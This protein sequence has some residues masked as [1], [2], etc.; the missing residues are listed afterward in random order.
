MKIGLLIIQVILVDFT[1]H[2]IMLSFQN[3]VIMVKRG[4]SNS[5]KR[6]SPTKAPSKSGGSKSRSAMS[7]SSKKSASST[8]TGGKGGARTAVSR[9]SRKSSALSG[10]TSVVENKRVTIMSEE[11]QAMGLR[12]LDMS[13]QGMTVLQNSLFQSMYIRISPAGN[14]NNTPVGTVSLH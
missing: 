2:V 5:P 13:S 9:E 3:T 7:K 10:R 11:M 12:M 8:D 6:G 14:S 4:K 1:N